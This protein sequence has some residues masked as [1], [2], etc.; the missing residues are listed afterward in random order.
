[1]SLEDIIK[2]VKEEL[3]EKERK[4]E[5]T[6]LKAREIRRISTKAIREI[7]KENYEKAEE[8]LLNARK[9]VEEVCNEEYA[10]LNEAFQEFGEACLTLA[11][12]RDKD[13]PTPE[14]LKIPAECYVFGLADSVGELRRYI[15]NSIRQNK[16]EK[17]EYFLDLM[18]EI[19][20]CLMLIDYPSS[21]RRKQ[22]MVR[23][24]LEKT[25]GD[26]TLALRQAELEK[27][28]CG[29]QKK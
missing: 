6:Y 20:H 3:D 8:Y 2:K 1:M 14:E 22:D 7:H 11:F 24:L 23:V 27:K 29:I 19:Y 25:Q 26:V 13:I 5:E 17:I 4:R 9:L 18:D 16:T 28:L 15:L 12:L 21:V 10:F